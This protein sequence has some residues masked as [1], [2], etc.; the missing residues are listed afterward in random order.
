V[1][2]LDPLLISEIKLSQ[3]NGLTITIKDAELYGFPDTKVET[4]K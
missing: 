1:P 2:A 4:L 3:S